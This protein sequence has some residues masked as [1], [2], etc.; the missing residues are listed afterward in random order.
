M[1]VATL[2]QA[3]HYTSLSPHFE[4]AF[5]FLREADLTTVAPGKHVVDD[6]LFFFANDEEGRGKGVIPLEYHKKYADLHYI[7]E[8]EECIGIKPTNECTDVREPFQEE[9][10]VGNFNDVPVRWISVPKGSFAIF[11]ED[12]AH[13]SLSGSGHV[14]KVV[15]KVLL[16]HKN[17]I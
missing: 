10:D 9:K 3:D 17:S 6:D 15:L 1:V 5:R 16:E 8:G 2:E 12:D 7:V 11:F 14:K 13:A 4:R